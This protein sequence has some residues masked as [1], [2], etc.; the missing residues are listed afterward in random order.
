MK[1]GIVS[2]AAIAAFAAFADGGDI[3]LQEPRRAGGKPLMRTLAE[4]RTGRDFSDR[5]LSAETLSSLLWAAN[6]INRPDGRRTAPTGLN[7]Q[8]IDVYVI[9][10]SG[11]YLHDAKENALKLV[12][13]GDF[14]AMA[15]LQDFVK[16]APVN[17]FCVQDLDRAKKTFD[18]D[19]MRFGGIHAG[20]VMQNIYLF[21]A[22]EG[23]AT[24]ARARLDYGELS[25]ILKL[26]PS[27][28]IIIGQTVGYP[29]DAAAA[30]DNAVKATIQ[31]SMGD[32]ELELDAEK[33]PVFVKN[34]EDYAASGHYDGTI[35][36]RVI[37]GFM[38]QGGGFTPDM[39]QKDTRPPI[40]NEA[41]N[42]LGN[43]RGT[44]AMARTM[45]VDSATSQF[46][47]NLTDNA[48][49]DHRSNDP[50]GFGYAVF[51]HVTK[52]MDV[53]D[54]IARVKT[55]NNGFHQNVPVEAV[56]INKVSVS[57]PSGSGRR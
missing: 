3:R 48:F 15:G 20:A 14:R 7:V 27:Q 46:F 8:D 17:L 24:V 33:A 53:V 32:I 45:V 57:R 18:A 54:R 44:I 42:G 6:G 28:R 5:E 43:K 52:G 1:I 12:N 39:A 36:H 13:E 19:T 31:T 2:I 30:P 25:K 11:V 10:R 35:F 23:L 51:G 9:L 38:I 41:G 16:T 56:K 37:N 4:R 29:P 49:L 26:R 40:R 47:I 34:F 55:G 22:S 50:Q 21:C